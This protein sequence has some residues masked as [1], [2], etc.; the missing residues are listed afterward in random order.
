MPKKVSKTKR[1]DV[2]RCD[3]CLRKK[4]SCDPKAEYITKS[5]NRLGGGGAPGG[6]VVKNDRELREARVAKLEGGSEQN[7]ASAVN[8]P[9]SYDDDLRS[10]T[11]DQTLAVLNSESSNLPPRII[12]FLGP[13]FV[14]PS[15]NLPHISHL[16]EGLLTSLSSSELDIKPPPSFFTSFK[17]TDTLS[18][19]SPKLK[20][21][22]SDKSAVALLYIMGYRFVDS[23]LGYCTDELSCNV[24]LLIWSGTI[25]Q[26][27]GS[28][29]AFLSL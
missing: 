6:G 19:S 10:S 2:E 29:D 14:T 12:N 1:Q 27:E 9:D 7:E 23:S 20:S 13:D 16:I 17:H 15:S 28:H 3:Q 18:S 5:S 22:L 25:E 21:L 8:D 11:Y 24:T 26:I 4:C